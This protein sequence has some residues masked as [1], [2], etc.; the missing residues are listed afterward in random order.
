MRLLFSLLLL[1]GWGVDPSWAQLIQAT[2]EESSRHRRFRL[3]QGVEC[4]ISDGNRSTI[5]RGKLAWIDST[6][7][8]LKLGPGQYTSIQLGQVVRMRHRRYN[9]Q[10]LAGG[11]AASSLLSG[12]TVRSPTLATVPLV[13]ASALTGLGIALASEK[14]SFRRR[15]PSIYQGWRFRAYP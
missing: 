13:A 11:G 9:R 15:D 6:S 10:R 7:F 4:Q 1:I 3:H 5:V 14:A 8:R 12:G 2:K